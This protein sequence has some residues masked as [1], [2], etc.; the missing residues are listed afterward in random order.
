[1]PHSE[2][3]APVDTTWLRMDRPTNRMVILGVLM[4]Q[5]PVDLAR[6]D[7]TLAKRMLAIP[8]FRQ[9]VERVAGG[10]RW[11]EDPHLDVARHI[12]HARL[13]G[14]GGKAELQS[15]VAELA[16]QA[17]DENRPLWQFHI[18]EDY[19][20]GAALV[21]R[22]HHAIADGIALI[23]VMLSLTDAAADAPEEGPGLPLPPPQPE[24]PWA[25]LLGPMSGALAEGLRLPAAAWRA[26]LDI[27]GDPAKL[28]DYARKGGGIAGELG[29]LLFMPNDTPTRFKG[30]LS[31]DKRVAW[32]DPVPLPEVKTV[33]R[34]LG[35]SVNDALLAAVAGAL[36]GYL[37]D[38]GD[39]V[40]GVELRAL[41]PINL[42][43]PGGVQELG[44]RF[45]VIAVE[46]PVGV[47]HP[48]NR[49]YEVHRRMELL[50]QSYEPAVTLGLLAALGY[51]PKL[52]QDQVFNLLLSRATAVMTNVPGPQQP[53]Y[54]A[55]SRL[56][57]VMFWVPQAGEIGM[58]LSI[59]SFDGK[60]QFGLITDAA[61][62]PDPDAIVG[63]IAP[64]FEKLLYLVLMQA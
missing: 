59:L 40:A 24:P 12:R 25:P 61:L 10:Y 44:N 6:L 62:V 19:A 4:L 47:A 11:S 32:S 51:T 46:L 29:Y 54:L 45:G 33:T 14:A 23:G 15:F 55:G 34:V 49:L 26:Y 60:V 35:C 27:L 22:M 8:R 3:M 52:V 57:E 50:K 21:V 9:R 39:P 58:G 48:L 63:R 42:R 36:H 38:K 16:P 2:Q 41:V 30:A 17:F 18:V 7:R 64:E 37:A 5:G 43:P 53:L 28:V 1:M 56:G 31:G 20:G 13:P